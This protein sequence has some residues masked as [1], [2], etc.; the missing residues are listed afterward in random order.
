[1]RQRDRGVHCQITFKFLGLFMVTWADPFPSSTTTRVYTLSSFSRPHSKFAPYPSCLLSLRWRY[2]CNK[3]FKCK[4]RY[5]SRYLILQNRS[6]FAFFIHEFHF[7]VY[8]MVSTKLILTT[9]L[10]FRYRLCATCHRVIAKADL[11]AFP[12]KNAVLTHR[13]FVNTC[14]I[15]S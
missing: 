11:R 7:M 13:Q 15:I 3:V 4:G 2:T 12:F 14:K 9:Y 1:M 8:F 6:K 5:F 10:V